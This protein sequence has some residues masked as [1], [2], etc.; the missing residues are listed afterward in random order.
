MTP[1][2]NLLAWPLTILALGFMYPWARWLLKRSDGGQLA[3]SRVLLAVTT[4]AL[5]LGTLSQVMLWTGLLGLPIDWRLTTGI[6]VVIGINGLLIKRGHRSVGHIPPL[7]PLPWATPARASQTMER[8]AMQESGRPSL[9]SGKGFRVRLQLVFVVLI[10][11]IA[12]LI[13]F[14]AVYWPFG[15][16]DAVAIYAWFGKQIALSGQLPHGT[17][18]EL[19]PM[20]VPLSYA[21]THQ[22]A[23]WIDEHLAAMIPALLSVGVIA[24]AYLLGQYL[25]D[26]FTGVIAALLVALTPMITHWA[27]TGYV[28]LPTAFFYGLAAVFLLRLE[29]TCAWQDTLLVGIAAGLA[30]WT[31]NSGLLVALSIAAWIA[32]RRLRPGTQRMDMRLI[33]LIAAA[34]LIVAGPWYTRNVI[35]AGTPVPA[36]GWTDKAE[37]TLSN[38]FPYI[39]DSRYFIPGWIFTA[40]MMLTI[41]QAWRARAGSGS[42]APIF[43]LIFYLPF[44]A[45]WWLFFSYDV[46]FLLALTPFVAVMGARAVWEAARRIPARWTQ[47]ARI[48]G[49]ALAVVLALPAAS[50]AVDYKPEL[51]RRPLMSDADKHRL[52][53]GADRYD[54]ALYLRTL[55]AGSRVWTQ[56]LLL[57]YHADGVQMTVGGWPTQ[58]QIAPYDYW[59]LSPGETLPDWFG[60]DIP[61]HVE[62]GYRLYKIAR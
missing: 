13:V 45:I 18:Y 3:E 24:V 1:G 12:G 29:R 9:Q 56:D 17:L 15:I 22:A 4:L 59:V 36:T 60:A 57:P 38:L 31:K 55:P 41:F 26:Q 28:D 11:V 42:F 34:F 43:L 6:C 2:L 7:A 10:G 40:G 20:L 47:Y 37:R 32:Y 48:G 39:A 54:M 8:G 46:R 44:F 16:D 61:V 30:A 14:N 19:Y 25:Y 35:V 23:G 49:V 58:E 50:A 52:R 27:S 33:M 51:L 21:F 62:G 5:S 53:L